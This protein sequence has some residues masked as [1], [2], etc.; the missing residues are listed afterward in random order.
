MRRFPDVSD[1]ESSEKAPAPVG[2]AR[3][4]VLITGAKLWFMVAGYVVQFALPRALADSAMG[5]W[6][7]VLAA[8]STLN[9]VMVTA[10]IQGVSKFSSERDGQS[11]AV[12]RAALRMQGVL[13]TAIAAGFFFLAPLGA[14][15]FLHNEPLVAPL[16][17]A[18][19]VV[20]CYSLYA[21]LV[22][23][24]NGTRAFHKQAGLD[25]TFS[26]LR[27]LLVVGA[28]VVTHS[29]LGAVGG[30]VAA[31]ALILVI[32]FVVVGLGPH[33]KTEPFPPARLWRFFGGVA[34]YLL[35]VN[36]LMFVDGILLSALE[37]RAG[38]ARGLS[39]DAAAAMANAQVAYYGAAQTVSRIPYQLILAVTFV[40]FPLVS[41][42]TF[43]ADTA[44]TRGY[45]ES[46]MR[47]SLVVVA[48]LAS[49]LAARPT[50][51]LRLFY[52]PEYTAGAAAFAVLAAGYVCFSLFN[53]AGTIINGAGRTRPT[54][55]I[56]SVTLAACALANWAA[57]SYALASGRDPLL[58]AA[59]ATTCAMAF[60]VLLSSLYLQRQLGASLPL[61]SIARVAAASAAAV[62]V[63]RFW[64]SGGFLGGKL[65]TLIACAAS[66][67]AF[68]AVA[69][70][71]GE[72]RLDA[73]KK[74]RR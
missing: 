47:Y 31:A 7:T 74:F 57:I 5:V 46:T 51:V 19:G 33:E 23:R 69:I 14:R 52:K 30:F 48:L 39:S 32:S 61:V 55:V 68:L 45:V 44:K 60:G 67:S 65:G 28:A 42:A 63:G 11:G 26:T 35:I 71:L 49:T 66:G 27:A 41:K 9:N 15:I 4:L 25:A 59:I 16:R 2:A 6:F 64:P 54:A 10:T 36:L 37:A 53:I 21:V 72:L 58:Y 34:F 40:I 38:L 56:G 22:G 73:L 3:G 24:A 17:I 62:G 70:G 1:S 29:V 50:A 8:V 12:A 18:A 13:G 20:L 43:E